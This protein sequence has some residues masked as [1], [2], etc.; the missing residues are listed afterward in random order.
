MPSGPGETITAK[1]L[2]HQFSRAQQI[3]IAKYKQLK[4]G[5]KAVLR[6]QNEAEYK[7]AATSIDALDVAGHMPSNTLLVFAGQQWQRSQSLSKF[8]QRA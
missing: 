1:G 8:A 3:R 6:S 7:C 5:F 2:L 4:E